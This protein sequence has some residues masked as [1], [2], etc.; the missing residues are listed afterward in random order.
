LNKA[1][2]VGA[3]SFGRSDARLPMQMLSPPLRNR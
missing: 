1:P 2:L 3:F